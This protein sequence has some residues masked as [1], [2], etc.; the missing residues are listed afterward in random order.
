L[1]DRIEQWENEQLA[2]KTAVVAGNGAQESLFGDDAGD[3]SF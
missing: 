2:G 1:L 3:K